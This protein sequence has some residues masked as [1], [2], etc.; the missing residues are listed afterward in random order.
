MDPSILKN[1][2]RGELVTTS[3]A[4]H[5]AAHDALVWNGR[6]PDRQARLIVRAACTEDVQEAVRFAAAQGMTVSARGGGHHFTGIA[7]RADMVIDLARLDGMRID[8]DRK[9]ARIEPGVTNLALSA[10]LG[11]HGLAFPVGHCG[12]VPVS[13]YL[14]GGGIGWNSGAWGIACFSVQAIEVVMADGRLLTASAN[15]NADI[16][17]AA[18]GAGSKFFGIATA[19]HVSLHDAPRAILTSVR[20]YGLDK[21]GQVA[22]WAE[23]AML[24]APASVEFTAK[25]AAPPPGIP[26]TGMVI[27]AIATVFAKSHSEG[28]SIL[29]QLG[30]KAPAGALHVLEAMPTPFETLYELTAKSM[31]EG[32]RYAADSLWSGGSY[33]DLL[34]GFA[35]AMETAPSPASLALVMLRS[36]EAAMPGDAAFSQIGRIFGSIYGIWENPSEDGA[37]IGWLRAAMDEIGPLGHGTYAGETDL[38]RGPRRLRTHSDA[39]AARIS[40]LAL[41]HDPAGLFRG[42]KASA[43]AA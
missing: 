26:A 9:S 2:L 39:A 1:R 25:I 23:E 37:N 3:D 5:A 7:T 24:A 20:F 16:F 35:A 30:E 12:S 4:S 34:T 27:A 32:R 21:A 42:A 8:V 43:E 41:K 19:Y 40:D 15:E 18:R 11:R 33:R 14:L 29:A 22:G 10:A 6:K 31:P 13:G 28:R 36:P 17:W 38:D